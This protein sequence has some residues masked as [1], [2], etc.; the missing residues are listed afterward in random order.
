MV[1]HA[2]GK[3]VV[4]H[5]CRLERGSSC[6]EL[7]GRV[8]LSRAVGAWGL[9]GL[10]WAIRKRPNGPWAGAQQKPKMKYANKK[11]KLKKIK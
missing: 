10:D 3:G 8:G 2:S 6:L 7:V 5:G 9:H 11:V 4:M 1:G